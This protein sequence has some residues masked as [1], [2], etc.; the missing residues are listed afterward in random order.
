VDGV[1]YDVSLLYR[2]ATGN[3]DAQAFVTS[4]LYGPSCCCCLAV[5]VAVVVVMVVA[6]VVVCVC[7]CVV[8]IKHDCVHSAFCARSTCRSFFMCVWCVCLCVCVF[9][10]VCVCGSESSSSV[11]RF[12]RCHLSALLASIS[13]H[14]HQLRP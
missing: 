9:V 11:F 3:A 1:R 12:I 7:V 10:C 5:V 2:D 8:A 13:L 4:V 6:V 14:P